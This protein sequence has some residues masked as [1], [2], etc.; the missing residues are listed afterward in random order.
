MAGNGRGAPKAG[1]KAKKKAFKRRFWTCRRT[2]DL[3][4]VQD[5]MQ[6]VE[7]GL[8]TMAAY[9]DEDAPG[10]GKFYCLVCAR[11]F[12]SDAILE[13][14]RRSKPHKRMVKIASE[15]QYTQAE[16]DAGA[17]MSR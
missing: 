17:G 10:G 1:T 8:R 6:A 14:H 11:H 4:Q 5:E 16:A 2:K 13:L 12:T 9:H 15:P 7:G 3:D